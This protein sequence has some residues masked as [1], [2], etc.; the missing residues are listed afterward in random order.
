M[1][2]VHLEK[3]EDSDTKSEYGLRV[4]S[5][6]GNI[7]PDNIAAMDV[8]TARLSCCQQICR[9]DDPTFRYDTDVH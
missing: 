1:C 8:V 9:K 4:S 7:L 6:T 3:A 2:G 5:E